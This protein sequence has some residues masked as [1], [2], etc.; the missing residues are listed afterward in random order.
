MNLLRKLFPR[1]PIPRDT[2]GQMGKLC[3]LLRPAIRKRVDTGM[4]F[5]AA[6]DD[7]EMLMHLREYMPLIRETL[8]REF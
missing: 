6:C 1:K 4:T 7:I 3:A 2:V 5:D 8:R